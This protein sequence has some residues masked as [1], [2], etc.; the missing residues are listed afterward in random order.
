MTR[1]VEQAYEAWLVSFYGSVQQAYDRGVVP[2]EKLADK[3]KNAWRDTVAY[4]C[5]E[6]ESIE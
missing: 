2:W 3:T 6:V 5:H 4:V 1:L